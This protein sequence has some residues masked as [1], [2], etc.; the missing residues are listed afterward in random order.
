[1]VLVLVYSVIVS[2]E[3]GLGFGVFYNIICEFFVLRTCYWELSYEC[4]VLGTWYWEL[5]LCLFSAESM[6]MLCRYIEC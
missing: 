2:W 4:F 3:H 5:S 6:C 1:M